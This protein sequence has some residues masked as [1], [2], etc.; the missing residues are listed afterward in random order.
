MTFPLLVLVL[1]LESP[2]IFRSD[3]DLGIDIVVGCR[4]YSSLAPDP[5]QTARIVGTLPF[6]P[7]LPN[8]IERLVLYRMNKGPSPIFDWVGAMGIKAVVVALRLGVFDTLGR[9]ALTAPELAGRLGLDA[10]HLTYLLD[11]LESLGY[12]SKRWGRYRNTPASLE[13]ILSSSPG[14]VADMLLGTDD[15]MRRWDQLE[16]TIRRGRPP[17]TG[18]ELIESPEAWDRYHRGLRAAAR[19]VG[20][21]VVSKIKLHHRAAKLLDAGGSHGYF[22]VEFCRANPGL[23]ATV[24]DWAEAGEIAEETISREGMRGRVRFQPGDFLTDDPG[25]DYDVVLLFNVIRIFSPSELA[26]LLSRA[27]GWL[28]P[29]GRLVVMDHLHEWM[30]SRL[31]RANARI[32]ELEL[33]NS[34]D[35]EI[36]RSKDVARRLKAA[37]YRKVRQHR[38]NRSPGLG[39]VEGQH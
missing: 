29:G 31:L 36:H 37:G 22:S 21:E 11:A 5:S 28:R 18:D 19:L 20:P 8:F 39:L 9:E 34:V 24:L 35:G 33:I 16:E 3:I 7:L 2:A 10:G 26:S 1:V 12:L 6:M 4:E 17:K 38:L 30:P 13:W 25:T 14:S 32:I 27:Q 15:M 23:T